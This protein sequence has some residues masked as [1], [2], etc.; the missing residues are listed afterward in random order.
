MSFQF[1]EVSLS[2]RKGFVFY[3]SWGQMFKELDAENMKRLMLAAIEYAE[4]GTKTEPDFSDSM[5]L[6]MLFIQFREQIHSDIVKYIATS[7]K[8]QINIKVRWNKAKNQADYHEIE[9]FDGLTDEEKKLKFKEL[10]EN[11][12]DT[13]LYGLYDSIELNTTVNDRIKPNTKFTDKDVDVSEDVKEKEGEVVSKKED[14]DSEPPRESALPMTT[15]NLTSTFS[16]KTSFTQ[17]EASRYF[18]ETCYGLDSDYAERWEIQADKEARRCVELSKAN[19]YAKLKTMTH[20]ELLELYISH[21]EPLKEARKDLERRRAEKAEKDREE[22]DLERRIDTVLQRPD[23]DEIIEMYCIAVG[24]EPGMRT[25]HDFVQDILAE[26]DDLSES[27]YKRLRDDCEAEKARQQEVWNREDKLKKIRNYTSLDDFKRLDGYEDFRSKVVA[28]YF[29]INKEYTDDALMEECRQ[30]LLEH[31]IVSL[32]DACRY[33]DRRIDDW[34][35]EE[36]L[37]REQE[38]EEILPF[39]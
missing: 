29:L 28:L 39:S 21:S 26:Y 12:L 1:K 33:I 2:E 36:R 10:A 5:L 32:K 30:T 6:R 37:R 19:G 20:V 14:S 7:L 9:A 8:N 17:A 35:A 27:G 4:S 25:P 34:K 38:E 22:A 16:S 15:D 3:H 11:Y 24:D 31:Q 18:M 23:I 13:G